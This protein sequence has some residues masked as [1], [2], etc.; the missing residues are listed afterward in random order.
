MTLFYLNHLFKRPS[1]MYLKVTFWG[2]EVRLQH[3]S[4]RGIQDSW[5][6]LVIYKAWSLL[7]N[8]ETESWGGKWILTAITSI[9][10]GHI[11]FISGPNSSCQQ[12]MQSE[13]QN[14]SSPGSNPHRHTSLKGASSP[15]SP[16]TSYVTLLVVASCNQTPRVRHGRINNRAH[17]INRV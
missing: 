5:K 7:T 12:S 6:H 17:G 8:C 3:T 14:I 9:C 11:L 10:L 16:A 1:S 15:T 2:M 13:E 4:L